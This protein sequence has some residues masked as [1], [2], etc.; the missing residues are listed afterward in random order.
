MF[1]TK[2]TCFVL[3]NHDS[4]RFAFDYLAR[5]SLFVVITTS[6][7]SSELFFSSKSTHLLEIRSF[8]P[9]DNLDNPTRAQGR[10]GNDRNVRAVTFGLHRDS[11]QWEFTVSLP[12]GEGVV[13]LLGKWA[14]GP[15]VC[16]SAILQLPRSRVLRVGLKYQLQRGDREREIIHS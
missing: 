14:G 2:E 5:H 6:R 15:L 4:V 10:P 8:D 12:K 16:R 3:P 9:C 13:P 1:E 7:E 11:T